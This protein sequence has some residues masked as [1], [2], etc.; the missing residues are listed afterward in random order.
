MLAILFS[1]APSLEQGPSSV[2][3]FV[4]VHPLPGNPLHFLNSSFLIETWSF[5]AVIAPVCA[6][7]SH[8]F[9]ASL[10]EKSHDNAPCSR[11]G[12]DSKLPMISSENAQ[13]RSNISLNVRGRDMGSFVE[14]AIGKPEMGAEEV[15]AVDA[16]GFC[17][18]FF[19]CCTL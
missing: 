14:E 1:A 10:H 6:V 7:A 4:F 5:R 19:Q 13:L 9:V 16:Y 3:Y 11:A 12:S 17:Q 8:P 18:Y 15:V 2:S